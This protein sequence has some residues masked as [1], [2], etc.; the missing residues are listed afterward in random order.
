MKPI[1]AGAVQFGAAIGAL[2]YVNSN[3]SQY[4]W[5][6]AGILYLVVLFAVQFLQPVRRAS[7]QACIRFNVT[8][9]AI[10]TVLML[11]DTLL[12]H[13]GIFKDTERFGSGLG[14]RVLALVLGIGLPTALLGSVLGL[15][16][17]RISRR[18]GRSD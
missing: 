13:R 6:V 9:A 16:I 1:A 5:T 12:L 2:I 14:Y 18:F 10:V 3:A 8:A 11:F 7:L 4:S 17:M 15:S